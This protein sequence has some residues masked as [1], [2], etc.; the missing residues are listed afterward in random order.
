MVAS[1]STSLAV[2]ANSSCA[3]AL[4]QACV[5][6]MMANMSALPDSIVVSTDSPVGSPAASSSPVTGWP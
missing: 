1:R 4:A 5:T 2:S 6:F 3:C